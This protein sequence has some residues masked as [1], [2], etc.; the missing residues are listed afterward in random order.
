M[1]RG[2]PDLLFNKGDLRLSLDAQGKE[3]VREVE[4]VPEEHVVRADAEEWA[5]ALEER[6]AVE[7]AR[8]LVDQIWREETQRAQVDVS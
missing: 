5:E 2:V 1:R 4:S 8:L 3:L 7:A 6:Y